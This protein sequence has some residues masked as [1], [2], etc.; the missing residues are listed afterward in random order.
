ML[1][2]REVTQSVTDYLD[3]A[4]GLGLRMGVRLHLMM[5]KNCRQHVEKMRQMLDGL[6]R[7]PPD[8][9]APEAWLKGVGKKR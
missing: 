1:T 2:C 6:E 8:E 4:L 3:N 7:L 5:C 9:E